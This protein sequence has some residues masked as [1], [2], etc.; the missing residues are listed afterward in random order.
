MLACREKA[1]KAAHSPPVPPLE[2]LKINKRGPYGSSIASKTAERPIPRRR[3]RLANHSS[4]ER[5]PNRRSGLMLRRHRPR[6]LSSR[7]PQRCLRRGGR[8]MF[9]RSL[10]RRTR[11]MRANHLSNG[12]RRHG[13][14][15]RPHRSHGRRRLGSSRH[16]RHLERRPS[17]L[18]KHPLEFQHLRPQR[19]SRSAPRP[20]RKNRTILRG[21]A[22][23]PTPTQTPIHVAQS[24]LTTA[25][26]LSVA[27]ALLPVR[28]PVTAQLTIR[29]G[30]DPAQANRSSASVFTSKTPP[31]AAPHSLSTPAATPAHRN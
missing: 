2:S 26:C 24:L 4:R 16:P 5:Q 20:T 7:S 1:H 17:R 12:S 13:H 29:R 30:N 11:R 28:F 14:R 25:P 27:Q 10:A 15:N 31:H 8:R 23:P 19:N 6:N 18:R 22:N 9:R 21:D 3:L